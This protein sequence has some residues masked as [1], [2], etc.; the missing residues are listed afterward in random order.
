MSERDTTN[1]LSLDPGQT[2]VAADTTVDKERRDVA[3]TVPHR[4]VQ[5]ALGGV[6]IGF[7]VLAA[8]IA[9]KTPAYESADEPGHVQNI[10]TLVAGHWYGMN[11]QCHYSLAKKGLVHC[12]GA[13]AHQAPLYYLLMAGWQRAVGIPTH[14]LNT[15][16]AQ[17]NDVHQ[18]IFV[19]HSASAHRFL[20]WLRLPNV[21][22]GALTVLFTFLAVCTLTSDPWTSVVGAAIVAYWPRFVF[23]SAFVTNDNLV[24][25]LGA[26]LTY[27]SLRYLISPTKG[28]LVLVA[29]TSGLLVTT[30]L[31]ALPVALGV[32][33]VLPLFPRLRPRLVSSLFLGVSTLVAVCGWYLV[34]NAVR[35]GDPLASRA[36][37]LYLEQVGGLGTVLSPYR[38]ASPFDLIF[39]KVPI[40]IWDGFWYTSGWNQFRV[41]LVARPGV[42]GCLRLGALW[43]DAT[44]R[45]GALPTTHLVPERNCRFESALRLDCRI[46][47]EHL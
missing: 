46:S 2:S 36:S 9:I 45:R 24:D 31:S 28:R 47:D 37:R 39:V 44:S 19:N 25:L 33:F 12:S 13:E 23:L 17:L 41:A 29:A 3:P 38:V 18:G 10:E 30:K 32:V 43:T 8:V 1:H 20:L 34:Q 21:L 26:V 7:V 40:R 11:S 6:I 14:A 16:P 42:L 15:G 27:L 4:K 5:V 22:L 35:Y